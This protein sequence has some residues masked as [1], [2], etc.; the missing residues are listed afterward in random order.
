MEQSR[1]PIAIHPHISISEHNQPINL[2][3]GQMRVGSPESDQTFPANGNIQLSWLPYSRLRFEV[4]VHS[5]LFEPEEV[6]LQ[7]NDGTKINGSV[8]NV[9]TKLETKESKLSGY[10][11]RDPILQPE[12]NQIQVHQAKF[13]VP[14]FKSLY[15]RPVRYLDSEQISKGRLILR[16][17]GWVITLD[18]VDQLKEIEKTLEQS[19]GFA[20]THVG[21][22]EKDNSSLFNS[23]DALEILEAL[24]WYLW[25]AKGACTSPCLPTGF[26]DAGNEVWTIWKHEIIKPFSNPPSWLDSNNYN[27]FEEPFPGFIDLWFDESWTEVIKLAIHWYVE[28]NSGEVTVESSIVLTQSALELLASA[29][30]VENYKLYSR[31]SYEKLSAKKRICSLFDWA[32]IPT[33]LPPQLSELEKYAREKDWKDTTTAMTEIRN[34]ITHPTKKNR[35]K[36]SGYPN[37]VKLEVHQLGLWNLELCLLRLFNYQNGYANRLREG[38]FVGQLDEVPWNLSSKS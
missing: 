2:Y 3:E 30:L 38:R 14:N 25:F 23:T 1:P 21:Q 5:I 37:K 27:Q 13:I 7:L 12:E 20:V 28:A 22:L 6:F 34:K 19:S 16:G 35:A 17:G 11:K 29:V 10:I 33:Q 15:A 9:N 26:N 31:N 18:P 4:L 8:L 24:T 36:L 32:G